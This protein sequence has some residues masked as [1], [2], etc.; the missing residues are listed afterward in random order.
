MDPEIKCPNCESKSDYVSSNLTS[1]NHF[2]AIEL[3]QG[4]EDG[5]GKD[6]VIIDGDMHIYKTVLTEERLGRTRRGEL[7]IK[8][9]FH[10]ESCHALWVNNFSFH[11]GV[12]LQERK[13]LVNNF[14]IA[15]LPHL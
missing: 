8:I 2:H 1:H 6:K 12:Y 10:C 9:T 13:V 4:T 3:M 11:K 5:Y 7:E 14:N 15:I